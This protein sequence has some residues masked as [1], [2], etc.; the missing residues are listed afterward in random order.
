[1]ATSISKN[2]QLALVKQLITGT[3]K[4]FTDGSS[5]L[6]VGG[7]TFTVTDLTQFLQNF[8]DQRDAVETSRAAAQ[9]KLD[10]ERAL[11][12]SSNAVINAF[13]A[14]VRGMFGKSADVLAD[15]GLSP[16]KA[17]APQTAEQ[18][19]VAAA[20]RKATRAARNTMGKNQKKSVKGAVKASL[21]VTP[22]PVSTPTASTPTASAAAPAPQPAAPVAPAGTATPHVP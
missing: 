10:A 15:F 2:R 19:A 18:K 8:V 16:P 9:A 1:M 5:K 7:A 21:V 20:K 17:R 13:I 6:S 14:L 4:H 11:A 22:L 12:T 3:K